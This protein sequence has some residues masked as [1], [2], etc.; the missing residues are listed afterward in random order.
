[1]AG[2]HLVGHGGIEMLH[3]RKDI[4]T[5]TPESGELLIKVSAAGINNT[6]IN[7]R[8][9]WY[10]KQVTDAT[11]AG[12]DKGFSRQVDN[13]GTWS[14]SPMT[15]PRIQGADYCGRVVDAGF[16]TDT[17]RIGERVIIRP[18]MRCKAGAPDFDFM[19]LG[20]EIDGAFTQY[21]KI[22]ER[23][24]YRVSSDWSD[25]ELA[26]VP[27]AYSTAENMLHRASVGAERVLITG[28]SGGVGSAAVQLAKRR[29]ALVIASRK[30]SRIDLFRV[31]FQWI[32][33]C[34]SPMGIRT[35]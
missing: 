18:M 22:S 2:V 14:G 30:I 20:S 35:L 16:G 23:E 32:G 19:T 13:D 17:G 1:M 15:F 28:A 6:D 25:V 29:G 27:C 8:I 12:G 9:G 5:P 31:E 26:S 4:P 10:S 11:D 24:A 3:Y 7:T 21:V 33:Q 34:I